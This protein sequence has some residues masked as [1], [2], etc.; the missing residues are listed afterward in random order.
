MSAIGILGGL[1]PQ[2]SAKLLDLIIQKRS[3]Q[4]GVKFDDDFPEIVLLNIRVPNFIDGEE[5]LDRVRQILISKT[6]VLEQSGCTIAAVACNTA[7]IFLPAIKR[8]SSLPFLSIPEIVTERIRQLG[9]TKV[10]LIGTKNTLRSRMF[11]EA[12]TSSLIIRP[13]TGLARQAEECILNQISGNITAQE[14][15]GFR[16]SVS[17]FM[18]ENRLDGVILGCT[19]LPLVFGESN[20]NP[21]IIDTLDILAEELLNVY[22]NN[23]E[24]RRTS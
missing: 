2:A 22:Y 14:K 1:G 17:Q 15:L 7:H 13:N 3:K 21:K 9:F 12:S 10:G 4:E 11:D 20:N 24:K 18:A 6:K 19:E 8:S 23:D 5:N 16:K